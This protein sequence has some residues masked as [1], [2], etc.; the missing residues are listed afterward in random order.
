MLRYA[1]ITCLV[2]SFHY[3]VL[4]YIFFLTFSHISFPLLL[5][6]RPTINPLQVLQQLRTVFRDRYNSWLLLVI[7]SLYILR[8]QWSGV[9]RVFV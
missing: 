2:I 4:T 9:E 7:K 3:P 1:Y 6:V 5:F 8:R